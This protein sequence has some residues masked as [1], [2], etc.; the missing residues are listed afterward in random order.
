[1]SIDHLDPAEVL[2]ATTDALAAMLAV[3]DW[4]RDALCAEYEREPFFA[5]APA[6]IAKAKA[7][8]RGCLVRDECLAYAVEHEAV[9]VWGG[10]STGERKRGRPAA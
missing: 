2:G 4:Q 3:P 10:T 1:M 5:M 6:V 8:C 9:G 7:I